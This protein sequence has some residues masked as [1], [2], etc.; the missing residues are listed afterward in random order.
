MKYKHPVWF[1]ALALSLVLAIP[2]E[3]MAQ[4]IS[5]L[6]PDGT[7]GDMNISTGRVHMTHFPAL[8]LYWIQTL[9]SIAGGCAVIMLMYGG[10]MYMF[11]SV[12]NNK[13]DGKK[14]ITYALG[15]LVLAFM[16][17]WIVELIQVWITS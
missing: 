15:G 7:L 1:T 8:I 14:A 2:A 11:G 4:G 13:E 12:T 16:A 3:L 10:V 9:L 5:I 6:P 17:W